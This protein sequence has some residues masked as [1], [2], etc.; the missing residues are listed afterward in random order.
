MQ[1][2]IFGGKRNLPELSRTLHLESGICRKSG[3]FAGDDHSFVFDDFVLV[4]FLFRFIF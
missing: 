3:L 4:I 1:K 2:T